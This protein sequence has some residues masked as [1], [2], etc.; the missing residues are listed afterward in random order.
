MNKTLVNAE[1]LQHPLQRRSYLAPRRIRVSRRMRKQPRA[2]R[3]S[4]VLLL[5][6]GRF[7]QYSGLPC[8]GGRRGLSWAVVFFAMDKNV[9]VEE[10]AKA[11]SGAVKM[12]R[13]PSDDF[14]DPPV[15]K[16]QKITGKRERESMCYGRVWSDH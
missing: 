1:I 16:R 5:L 11:V 15:P 13:P 6:L 12:T 8:Q 3:S 2:N 7:D 10:I 4:S 9:P 14:V